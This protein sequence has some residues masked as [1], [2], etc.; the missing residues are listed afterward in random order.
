MQLQAAPRSGGIAFRQGLQIGVA[1]GV[2]Q[3]IISLIETLAN[4]G[5]G[6]ITALTI[7][8]YVLAFVAYFFAGYRASQQTAKVSTGLLAGLWTGLFAAIISFIYTLIYSV[9]N[10]NSL[11]ATAQ[12]AANQAGAHFTY[13]SSL[14]LAFVAGG[15][16]L[17]VVLFAAIGLAIG[18]FGGAIGKNRANVASQTYQ[19]AMFVPPAPPTNQQ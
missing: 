10:M 2:I 15:A 9:V 4:L 5:G 19:E 7:I 16:L 3:A 12:R 18:A 13:T 11:L 6:A 1:L 14:L 17:V 8:S